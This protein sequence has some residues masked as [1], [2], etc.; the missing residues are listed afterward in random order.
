MG[1]NPGLPE[2]FSHLAS[3]AN[4]LLPNDPEVNGKFVD[5]TRNFWYDIAR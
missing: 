3:P 5:V 4:T 2:V 1:S